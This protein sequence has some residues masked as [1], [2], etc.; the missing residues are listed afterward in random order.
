MGRIEKIKRGLIMEANKRLLAEESDSVLRDEIHDKI[1]KVGYLSQRFQKVEDFIDGLV[2][3][4]EGVINELHDKFNEK[5]D[6]KEKEG[7]PYYETETGAKELTFEMCEMISLEGEKFIKDINKNI[8]NIKNVIDIMIEL[9]VQETNV[10]TD[11]TDKTITEIDIQFDTDDTEF[12]VESETEFAPDDS[13]LPSVAPSTPQELIPFELTDLGFNEFGKKLKLG[14]DNI[15]SIT[16][17][18]IRGVKPYHNVEEIPEMSDDIDS[19]IESKI[20]SK[21]NECYESAII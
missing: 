17:L 11:S 1:L 18:I 4:V 9:N 8:L 20:V 10:G 19:K 13:N 12:G 3:T 5:I 16:K 14:W 15:I 2:D 7:K 6:D 21:L